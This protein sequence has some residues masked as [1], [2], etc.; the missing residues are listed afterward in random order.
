MLFYAKADETE[1]ERISRLQFMEEFKKHYFKTYLG[2]FSQ[3]TGILFN[4]L[5]LRE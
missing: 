2:E 4:N 5:S 3:E 1:Q